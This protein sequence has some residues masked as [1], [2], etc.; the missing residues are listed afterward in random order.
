MNTQEILLQAV[1]MKASD[2]HITVGVPSTVRV[3][4]KLKFIDDISLTPDDAKQIVQELTNSNQWEKLNKKGEVDFSY[5]IP[6]LQ[7]FR[8]NAY[9]QKNTYSIALRLINSEIPTFDALGLPPVVK[10]LTEKN[11]GLVLVT[12]PT[13]S[14]KS[15]TLASML[16]K[17]NQT[18]DRHIITL[19][20]PIEYIFHHEKSIIGQREIGNDTLNFGNALRASLRQDPDVILIG[21]MRDFDTISIAL[22]AAETGHLV[23]ST[24]H[25]V[26]AAATIDRIIDVFPPNQQQQV[27]I[28]LAMVL[29]GVI[30]QQLLTNA[31]QNGRV[32][33]VEVM[34][35]NMAVRN[36]IRES[37]VHQLNS[38]IQT[39]AKSGMRTMDDSLCDLYKR[40]LLTRE[41]TIEHCV[42]LEYIKKLI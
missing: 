8:V 26:G 7:R 15:T 19:E 31:N 13:G 34:L 36:M 22:T 11:S 23:F 14:G 25:T 29:Q 39:N 42:D 1:Q 40:G 18:R 38:V 10:D 41:D 27:R 28:Q 35:A 24:L 3:H 6:G 9:R 32:V 20:D 17:I 30:S 33:A 12:G 2:I 21:E 4:G 16:Q 5:A 37:K